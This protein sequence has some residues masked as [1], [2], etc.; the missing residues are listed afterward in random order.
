MR[1]ALRRARDQ[2]WGGVWRSRRGNGLRTLAAEI[3]AEMRQQG[4]CP[5][6][7]WQELRRAG[8]GGTEDDEQTS[9]QHAGTDARLFR[10]GLRFEGGSRAAWIRHG[11]IGRWLRPQ[12]LLL[13]EL[14]GALLRSWDNDAQA[15]ALPGFIE[16]SDA[17]G[18]REMR[19]A[20]Y[21][22]PEGQRFVGFKGL[23]G[24]KPEAIR[25]N[26]E[27]DPAI[28]RLEIQISDL[29]GANVDAR[30]ASARLFF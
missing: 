13:P 20:R 2:R 10:L 28:S 18:E 8:Q 7:G 4:T 21:G 9:G 25:G 30:S 1:G 19:E 27:D 24:L 5:A 23:D 14:K 29:I 6:C 17:A 16:P 12:I 26:V 22:K 15:A 11:L 3:P